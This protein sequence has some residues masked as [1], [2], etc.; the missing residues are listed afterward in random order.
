MCIVSTVRATLP[1][2]YCVCVEKITADVVVGI[3]PYHF[4]SVRKT[5]PLVYVVMT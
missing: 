3:W 1:G 5:I 4:S 2:F